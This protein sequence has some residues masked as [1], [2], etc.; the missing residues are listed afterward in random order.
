MFRYP[1]ACR[2]A[3]E[4]LLHVDNWWSGRLSFC[5]YAN[6]PIGNLSD[7]YAGLASDVALARGLKEANHVLWYSESTMPDLGGLEADMNLF[8]EEFSNPQVT[9]SGAYRHVCADIDVSDLA[10][11][12]VIQSHLIE[13][14]EGGMGLSA[15][16]SKLQAISEGGG[17]GVNEDDLNGSGAGGGGPHVTYSVRSS[18]KVLKSVITF[19]FSDLVH[20]QDVQAGMLLTS[21]YRWLRT[22][23]SLAYVPTS[24]RPPPSKTC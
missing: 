17:E 18:F 5:R 1:G 3:L 13:E 2:R 7:D 16:Q 19:W 6:L 20:Q 8:A 4:R 11:N 10:V 22:P 9:S 21:F 24:H 23:G 15:D 14:L 12:T